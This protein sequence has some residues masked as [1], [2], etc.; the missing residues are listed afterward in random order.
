MGY[1]P[2]GSIPH[3]L[4][5]FIKVAPNRPAECTGNQCKKP[6]FEGRNG[7]TCRGGFGKAKGI[8]TV[9][10]SVETSPDETFDEYLLSM[11]AMNSD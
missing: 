4:L 3:T 8:E 6:I 9:I 10:S 11:T 5:M 7:T 2:K 1:S